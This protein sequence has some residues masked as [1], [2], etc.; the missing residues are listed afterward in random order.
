MFFLSL[1]SKLGFHP[2]TKALLVAISAIPQNKPPLGQY[3][4]KIADMGYIPAS[5]LGFHPRTKAVLVAISAI[6]QNKPPLGQYQLKIA[7]MGYILVGLC[8]LYVLE[9]V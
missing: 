1:T 6:L 9:T 3:Q 5:K 2:C 8:F 4:L 7:D